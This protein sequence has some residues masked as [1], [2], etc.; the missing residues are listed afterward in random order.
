ML[1]SHPRTRWVPQKLSY[2]Y[3]IQG[4]WVLVSYAPWYKRGHHVYGIVLFN[5]KTKQFKRVYDDPS[6]SETDAI[7]VMAR[8]RMGSLPSLGISEEKK[9]GRILFF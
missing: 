8:S 1:P 4:D 7:P 3:P 2:P 5:L 6:W 9:T